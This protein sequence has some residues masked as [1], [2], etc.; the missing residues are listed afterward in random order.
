[1]TTKQ[2]GELQIDFPIDANVRK[3]DD[4][5]AHGLQHCMKA[6][7]FIVEQDDR[8]L[9]IE[10]K[11][12]DHSRARDDSSVEFRDRFTS[13]KLDEDLKYKYRDSFLYEWASGN[14]KKPIFYYVLI[15]MKS[16]T[17]ADLLARTDELKRKLPLDGPRSGAWNQQFVKGCVVFNLQTWNQFLTDFPVSRIRATED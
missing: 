10:F 17:K 15:G 9:F 11:D 2:E 16:L 1:M 12:P 14:T 5:Q 8:V 13:G 7:D 6:V 3:F 4:Q